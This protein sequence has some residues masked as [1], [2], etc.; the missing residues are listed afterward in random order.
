MMIL[1]TGGAGYIGAVT[2][3]ALLDKGFAVR[4]LD[5][6]LYGDAPLDEVRNHVDVVQGDICTVDDAVLDDIGAVVHLAGLSNDPTAEFNPEANRRMNSLATRSLAEACKRKGI[7]R[8]VFAS[9]CSIYDRGLM[10]EDVIQDENSPVQPLAAYAQSKF[11]AEQALLELADDRFQPTI[12]RQGTVYGWSPRMRYDLV[13]NTFVKSAYETGRLVVHCGGEMWRPL[14]D[15]TDVANCYITCLEAD[16]KIVGGQIFN[17]SHKNY[18]ILELA[19]WVRKA[20]LGLR[21]VEI[22][23][24]YGSQQARSYRVNT[25]KI[26]TV[27]GFRPIVSVEDSARNMAQKIKAGI[28]A[29]FNNPRYYNIRW[30][31]LLVEIQDH[32]RRIGSIF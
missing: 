19:H 1:V 27:L 4:V 18:R 10:A 5:K 22:D 26:E 14:V 25:R 15:V 31:E 16:L 30:L 7:R 11:A 9:S 20:L 21:D 3:R 17:V 23:V 24:Q 12:L 2:V 28:S 32:L 13:V 8:F 29:D 6:L